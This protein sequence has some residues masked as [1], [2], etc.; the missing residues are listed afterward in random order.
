MPVNCLNSDRNDCNAD[1]SFQL[2]IALASVNYYHEPRVNQ[3]DKMKQFLFA[4]L[5][6]VDHTFLQ[7]CDCNADIKDNTFLMQKGVEMGIIS[8]YSQL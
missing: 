4:N 1:R 8:S 2:Q 6:R 3:V 5:G 7:V